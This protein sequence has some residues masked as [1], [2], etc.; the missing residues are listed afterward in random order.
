[1]SEPNQKRPII[2]SPCACSA[3]ILRAEARKYKLLKLVCASVV[4]LSN[5]SRTNTY[6]LAGYVLW[7]PRPFTRKRVVCF[8]GDGLRV[9]FRRARDLMDRYNVN[10][11]QT[12]RA[13]AS[14]KSFKPH[15]PPPALRVYTFCNPLCVLSHS[16]HKSAAR[17]QFCAL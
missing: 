14:K 12:R 9:F 15:T 4:Y 17:R 6:E 16:T 2:R 5:S 1:M 13:D 7:Q 11:A 10:R 3:Q 8:I